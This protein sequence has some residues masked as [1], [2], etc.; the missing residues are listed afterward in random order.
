MIPGPMSGPCFTCPAKEAQHPVDCECALGP[1]MSDCNRQ[2]QAAQNYVCKWLSIAISVRARRDTM[3]GR[4]AVCRWSWCP[5]KHAASQREVSRSARF[6]A[7]PGFRVAARG[8]RRACGRC[9]ATSDSCPR[10]RHGKPSS[11]MSRAV[12]AALRPCAPKWRSA[13]RIARS[14]P[15]TGGCDDDPAA[16]PLSFAAL[17]W[18]FLANARAIGEWAVERAAAKW[19]GMPGT[20]CSDWGTFSLAQRALNF[21]SVTWLGRCKGPPVPIP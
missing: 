17:P 18:A 6:P 10:H 2:S 21:G 13:A 12:S 7:S 1:C 8:A 9:P 14:S 15:A 11:A 4:G 20:S 3:A 5:A 16:P 19:R